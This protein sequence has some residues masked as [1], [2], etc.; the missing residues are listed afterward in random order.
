VIDR[1]RTRCAVL[2]ATLATGTLGASEPCPLVAG[3]DHAVAIR[4]TAPTGAAVAGVTLVVDHPERDVGIP[5]EGIGVSG[6]VISHKP[7]DAIAS[8]ND[9]GDAVRVVLA[10]P[11]ELPLDGPLIRL[12]FQRCEGAKAPAPDAFSCTVRE[13]SDP[14]TNAVTG[15]GCTV[16]TP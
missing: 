2:L 12:H 11:G 1:R 5:G 15:V 8:A 6:A 14:V 4:L 10:R 9:L 7:A 13:A 16:G 3:S